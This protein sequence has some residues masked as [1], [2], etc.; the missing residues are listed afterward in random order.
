[1]IE[2]VT[3][4]TLCV[5]FLVLFRP[6]KTPPLDNPLVIERVGKYRMTLA[7]QLNLAQTLIEAI[8]KKLNATEGVEANIA[9][10]AFE[11]FDKHVATKGQDCYVLTLSR[12][13][14]VYSFEACQP[15]SEKPSKPLNSVQGEVL[16]AILQVGES[17]GIRL[18]LIE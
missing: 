8:I 14:G 2:T 12:Q 6:G 11:V 3:I 9:K 16:T 7:P 18:Q 4:I 15:S 10:L 5:T 13:E 1:M 17:Y